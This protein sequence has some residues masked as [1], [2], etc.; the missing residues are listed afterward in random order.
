MRCGR[1]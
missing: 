1:S